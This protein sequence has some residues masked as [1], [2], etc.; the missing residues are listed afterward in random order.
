MWP[1]Q[2]LLRKDISVHPRAPAL[3]NRVGGSCGGPDAPTTPLC[4]SGWA[5]LGQGQ[6]QELFLLMLL[7]LPQRNINH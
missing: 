5:G 7:R 1:S 4:P 3:L 6:W 2:A